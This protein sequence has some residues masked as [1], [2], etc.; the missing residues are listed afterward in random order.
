MPR[1]MSAAAS[2]AN[3]GGNLGDG[4]KAYTSYFNAT[5]HPSTPYTTYVDRLFQETMHKLGKRNTDKENN[6]FVVT[7]ALCREAALTASVTPKPNH[8]SAKSRRPPTQ[9]DDECLRYTTRQNLP[10]RA[11]YNQP[12]T[13]AQSYG[14]ESAPFITT[15]TPFSYR[16]RRTTEVTTTYGPSTSIFSPRARGEGGGFG[17]AGAGVGGGRVRVR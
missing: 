8:A 12:V 6:E 7:P 9:P 16:P 14:W 3:L 5:G 11:K 15:Q 1:R 10:P 2:A 17:S 4:R 13:A